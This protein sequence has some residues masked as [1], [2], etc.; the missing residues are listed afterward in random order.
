MYYFILFFFYLEVAYGAVITLKNHRTGGGY[1]HSHWHLYPEG[2]GARQ[3]QVILIDYTIYWLFIFKYSG[4]SGYEHLLETNFSSS[5]EHNFDLKIHAA[6]LFLNL[7]LITALFLP[8]PAINKACLGLFR[9]K[10]QIWDPPS[11]SKLRSTILTRLWQI[12]K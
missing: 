3:Q 7:P 8:S 1:L 11:P 4:P 2:V 5:F 12:K 9:I 10:A 6:K